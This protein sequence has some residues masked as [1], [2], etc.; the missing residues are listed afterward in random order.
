MSNLSRRMIL[1]MPLLAGLPASAWS[2]AAMPPL[3]ST[4]PRPDDTDWTSYAGD[5]ASRRYSPLDQITGANFNDLEVAWRFRTEAL[6]P[7]PEY[8]LQVTPLVANGIVYTTGGTRRSVVA[9]DAETGELLWM[10]RIDEGER[11]RRAPRRLSGRGLS[12][13]TDGQSER[14]LYVTIGYQLVALDARTGLRDPAFGNG[15]IVDLKQD[16]DQELDP[17]TADVGLHA[18]PCVVKDVVIVGAAHT[19]GA[20]P[21]TR[22]NV[23]GYVRAFDV[24]TGKRLWTFHTIPKAGEFGHDSWDNGTEN[25]GNAGVWCQISADPALDLVYLGVELPTGDTIG[26]YRRGNALFGESIVAVD[27]HTGERKWHYQTVHHGLWDYDIACAPILIDFPHRGRLVKALA[28]PSKQSF[29]YVLD[30]Q[31]GKPVWPIPEKPV[32]AG[33]VPGEWYA[34]TQPQP[35]K[36]PPYDV[37]GVTEDVLIDFTPELRAQAKRLIRNY[38]TGPLFTPPSLFDPG[39]TWGT[40]TA[41]S[42]TGGSN[43]P[44]G[45]CDPESHMVF[46]YSKTEAD[47]LVAT[48]NS[49]PAVSDFEYVGAGRARPNAGEPAV[50]RDGFR[51][52]AIT[53]QGL[54][55]LKPPYGRITAINLATGAIAWQ[56]AHG[57][58]PDEVTNH[59]ALKGLTIPRTGR[60]GLLGTLTTKTLLICGEAG[61]ATTETGKRGAMLR[62]YDKQTGEEKGAVY[63]PAPQTGSPMTYI[64]NGRQYI[65][66]AIGGGRYGSE[67]VAYRLPS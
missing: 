17:L 28:L 39:G 6:G 56:I 45:S 3:R 16:F 51:P 63:M 43:W 18:T 29:L 36:P 58:T 40:L 48:K 34:P 12:Y 27:L 25:I 31:T 60:A 53:V 20:R 37:Q 14:I 42:L 23:K 5:L 33:N 38:R 59:P 22:N 61:F 65:V 1:S 26:N 66:L 7:L 30:R 19:P 49:D 46:V 55:L 13:W 2:G 15:G 67:L 50:E 35:S 62:A 44:G 52:G 64:L 24:R 9:L 10:H 8:N 41:P 32:P 54:P 4:A 47:V 21:R 57:S 11:A